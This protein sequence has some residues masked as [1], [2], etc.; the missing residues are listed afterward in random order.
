MSNP[1]TAAQGTDFAQGLILT[2]LMA[3]IANAHP[4]PEAFIKNLRATVDAA[5]ANVGYGD[6]QPGSE[7]DMRFRAAAQQAVT[8]VF[9]GLKK[10]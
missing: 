3:A 10:L 6:I 5:A 8:D 7:E 1:L 2:A 4:D 9:A